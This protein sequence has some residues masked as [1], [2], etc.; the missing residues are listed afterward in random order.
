M[1]D[2]A[3]CPNEPESFHPLPDDVTSA[4]TPKIAKDLYIGYQMGFRASSWALAKQLFNNA[5]VGDY[6]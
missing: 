5:L 3:E 2:G 4:S 6:R 1:K